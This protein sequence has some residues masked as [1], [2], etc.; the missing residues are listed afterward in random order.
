MPHISQMSLCAEIYRAIDRLGVKLVNSRQS[1]AVI[2]AANHIVDALAQEHRPA[3]PGMGVT[4]WLRSDDTGLSSRYMLREIARE[5]IPG[6]PVP[7]ERGF[8]HQIYYP[9]DPSDLWRCVR[10]LEAEPKLREHIGVLSVGHGSQWAALVANWNELEAMYREEF[11][12]GQFP[13][14][15]ARMQELCKE[16]S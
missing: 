7:D 15:Y 4:A 3:T 9:H 5:K 14:L 12:S 8:G 10:L 6:L 2:E 16:S 1:N 11:S 13:K